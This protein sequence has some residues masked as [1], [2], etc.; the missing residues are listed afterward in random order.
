MELSYAELNR[1]ANQLA[2]ALQKRGVG[3][4]VLVAICMRR[5]VNSMLAVLG[6]LKAGGAYVPI[7]PAFPEARIAFMLADSGAAVVLTDEDWEGDLTDSVAEVLV[8]DEGWEVFSQEGTHAPPQQVEGGDLAYVMYTSGSTGVPKGVAMPHRALANLIRWQLEN[9]AVPR[10]KTLQF[11]TLS[12]DVSFQEIFATWCGGGT[13]VLLSEDEAS[14]IQAVGRVLAETR[15]ERLFLPF[16]ALQHLADALDAEALDALALKE[17]ITAGEQLRITPEITRLFNHLDRCVLNNQYGPTETHV[18][19]AH[20]LTGSPQSW[21]ALPP[22]GTPIDNVQLYILSDHLEP[23]PIGVTGELYVGGCALARSY[24][25]RP[26]EDR[27][28]FLPHP[29]DDR[30]GA[31]LYKTGDLAR[32]LRSGEIAFLGRVD[33]QVKIRG[34]RIEPGEIEAALSDQPGVQACAVVVRG[35][36]ADSRLVAFIVP[37]EDGSI[38]VVDLKRQLRRTLPEYMLPAAF[39]QLESL[40]LTASGKVDRRALPEPDT[41]RPEGREK[42]LMPRDALERRIASVWEQ[43]LGVHSIGVCE[44]F[45]DLG[46]HSLLA[47]R[48]IAGLADTTGIKLPIAAMFQAPTIEDQAE[49]IRREGWVETDT[50]LIPIRMG[51]D[52]PPLFLVHWAGGNVLIYRELAHLLPDDRSVYGLQALGLDGRTR[53]HT[54]VEQMATHYIREIR[55]IRPTGPYHLGGASLGG[56]IAFEMARQL[57]S[58]GEEVGL[59]ALFDAIGRPNQYALPVPQRVELHLQNLQERSLPGKLRYLQDRI[60]IRLTRFLYRTWIRSGLPLPHCMWNVKETTYYAFKVYRPGPFDVEI[61]LFRAEQRGPASK[62]SQFL[63]WDAVDGVHIRTVPVPGSH[64]TVLTEPGVGVVAATLRE[65]L[66]E[67]EG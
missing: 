61:L 24:H 32:Y 18:V 66:M 21:P 65:V 53:P 40:P 64:A 25:N 28:R 51:G 20:R 3:P 23:V 50:T 17:I 14:D 5:S 41:Q 52:K 45:F 62:G 11:T 31:R 10:A 29:F 46:G 26:E 59:V 22:I 49:L 33:D 44:D 36:A 56:S 9:S 15:V 12:F 48:L 8:V 2:R 7:D 19:S 34:Y 67:V 39:V 43:V 58:Q 57:R 16:A 30:P 63:G 54:T 37:V 47:V 35:E 1:K 60:R 27:E 38:D 6:V 4:D 55:E 42:R 13:L